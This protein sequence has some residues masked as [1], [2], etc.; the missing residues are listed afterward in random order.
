MGFHICNFI[1]YIDIRFDRFGVL[2][3]SKFWRLIVKSLNLIPFIK[4]KCV[5]IKD[6]RARTSPTRERW[7]DSASGNLLSDQYAYT[8]QH[9]CRNIS[10]THIQVQHTHIYIL[11]LC[12]YLCCTLLQELVLVY[13][14]MG[15][16]SQSSL[17]TPARISERN[18]LPW[19]RK[20]RDQPTFRTYVC[21]HVCTRMWKTV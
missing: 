19:D 13:L 8:T 20:F 16:S 17:A 6:H 3:L 21:M 1:Q 4:K 7:L 18:I 12:M 9:L 5:E 14:C 11:R 2:E 10:H 15:T